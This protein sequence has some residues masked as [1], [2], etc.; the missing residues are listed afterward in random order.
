VSSLN[1]VPVK[2][3]VRQP[4]ALAKI[5]GTIV[6][7]LISL[8]IE[9][10]SFSHPS[11]F[12]AEFAVSALPEANNVAW[13]MKTADEIGVELFIGFP[14][15]PSDYDASDLTSVFYGVADDIDVEW[16]TQTLHVSGRDLSSK[17]ADVKTAEKYINKTA[18][19]VATIL[20]GM[21][22]LTPVVTATT[23]LIG[24][25]YQLDHVDLHDDQTQ[26]DLLTWLAREERFV[27]FVQNKSLY[28]QPK[29]SPS[30][31]PYLLQWTPPLGDE[32]F[33]SANVIRLTT[34]R[35][36]AL[37]KGIK[38]AVTSWN[39][40][41]NQGYTKTAQQ[42]GGSSPQT[43]S[44][45]IA[46]LDPG[47]CQDRANQLLT[48]LSQHERKISFEGPADNILR[49]A[50]VIQLSGTGTAL[51]QVYYP[52]GIKRSFDASSGYRWEIEARTIPP[53]DQGDA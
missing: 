6:D 22:G 53:T 49:L 52:T 9:E 50:N 48:E 23:T 13:W 4:R 12:R 35:E 38:V 21:Y 8:E 5:N 37:A 39:A 2:S 44:W 28:F 15:D 17:L 31:T 41:H 14:P 26:W 45:V 20:A 51:D 11:T 10:T 36:L 32:G 18:S 7:G 16:D 43:Y 42:G 34:T 3:V 25:Y 40:K 33:N 19:A 30:Q 1:S 47:D 46:G 29:P 24:K 27:C